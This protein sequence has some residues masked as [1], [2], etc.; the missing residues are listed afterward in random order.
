M[1]A[2]RPTL[3]DLTRDNTAREGLGGIVLSFVAL[4]VAD[5]AFNAPNYVLV[6]FVAT[7]LWCGWCVWERY[8]ALTVR[9]PSVDT[10]HT[11]T[12]P[13]AGTYPVP[14]DPAPEADGWW[15]A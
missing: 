14:V 15:T 2:Q 6:L 10:Y 12:D 5:A 7:A 4:A 1:T 9:T 11:E 8:E 3:A 13:E